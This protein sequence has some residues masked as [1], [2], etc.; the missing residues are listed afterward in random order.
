M[1]KEN[2]PKFVF[3]LLEIYDLSMKRGILYVKD[4]LLTA[5]DDF[6]AY[7]SKIMFRCLTK[8][9]DIQQIHEILT[10]YAMADKSH[11]EIEKRIMIDTLLCIISG[12]SKSYLVE[13]QASLLNV[14]PELLCVESDET[15][16]QREAQYFTTKEYYSVR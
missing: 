7:L 13:L 2:I 5:Q 4:M 8:N 14:D 9:I 6:L 11:N 10:N 1:K 16:V 12:E 15:C 3:D